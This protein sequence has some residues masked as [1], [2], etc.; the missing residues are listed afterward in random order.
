MGQGSFTGRIS[1]LGQDRSFGGSGDPC[2]HPP[3]QRGVRALETPLG[4]PQS[5]GC[6]VLPSTDAE[7]TLSLP[8]ALRDDILGGRNS[9]PKRCPCQHVYPPVTIS[10]AGVTAGP[11]LLDM[12]G[13][14]DLCA[15]ALLQFL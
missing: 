3:P 15:P 7:Q 6:I 12:R 10:W 4:W 13:Y 1:S 2:V 5:Q 11:A 9:V 14:G 8:K